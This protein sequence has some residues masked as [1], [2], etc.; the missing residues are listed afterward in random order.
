MLA[1]T[2]TVKAAENYLNLTGERMARGAEKH[3]QS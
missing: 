3:I 2:K 1:N